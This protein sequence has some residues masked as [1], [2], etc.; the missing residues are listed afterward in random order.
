LVCLQLL[1]LPFHPFIHSGR[2]TWM[3]SFTFLVQATQLFLDI[4][5][6]PSVPSLPNRTACH[7]KSSLLRGPVS[8]TRRLRCLPFHLLLISRHFLFLFFL[9]EPPYTAIASFKLLN[10]LTD[11]TKVSCMLHLDAGLAPTLCWI[12]HTYAIIHVHLLP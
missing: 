12:T 6:D 2:M 1:V 7:G 4:L 9:S 8:Y 3:I 11:A 5:L 10:T